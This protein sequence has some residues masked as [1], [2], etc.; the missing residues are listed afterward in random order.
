M[1]SFNLFNTVLLKPKQKMAVM[2]GMAAFLV[3]LILVTSFPPVLLAQEFSSSPSLGDEGESVEAVS[4]EAVI[5]TAE[6]NATSEPVVVSSPMLQ[7][8]GGSLGDEGEGNGAELQDASSVLAN[9][10][11]GQEDSRSPPVAQTVTGTVTFPSVTPLTGGDA[12]AEGLHG[13]STSASLG[14]EGEFISNLPVAGQ[15]AFPADEASSALADGLLIPTSRPSLGDEG[16]Q[17]STIAAPQTALSGG[18]SSSQQQTSTVFQCPGPQIPV[19][20]EDAPYTPWH[21]EV[22]SRGCTIVVWGEA[23]VPPASASIGDERPVT[24]SITASTP[25]DTAIAA[26]ASSGSLGNEGERT[27]TTVSAPATAATAASS[28]IPETAGGSLGDE[29]DAWTWTSS[30]ATTPAISEGIPATSGSIGDEGDGGGILGAP[31]SANGGGSGV[32]GGGNSS[33]NATPADEAAVECANPSAATFAELQNLIVRGRVLVTDFSVN[34]FAQ[35]GV[36]TVRNGTECTFSVTLATYEVFFSGDM[37]LFQTDPTSANPMPIGDGDFANLFVDLP[38]CM[39]QT[40]LL[41]GS[42]PPARLSAGQSFGQLIGTARTALEAGPFCTE[43]IPVGNQVAEL[44]VRSMREGVL[45][46]GVSVSGSQNGTSGVTAYTVTKTGENI[47]TVLS[48]PFL[49][50]NQNRFSGWS[51]DCTGEQCTIV[52]TPGTKKTVVANYVS[53]LPQL[54]G[55]CEAIPGTARTGQSIFWRVTASG[56]QGDY[57][58]AW[59]TGPDGSVSART[60]NPLTTFVYLTPGMKTM[61]A[62]IFSGPQVGTEYQSI[63]VTCQAEILPLIAPPPTG[64]S[65]LDTAPIAPPPTG[66]S[67]GDEGGNITAPP[68]GASLGDENV[69]IGAPPTGASL[70]DEGGNITT[71]PTGASIG[72]ENVPIGAPPTGASL[73]DEG[74]NITTPPTGASIG[75][76]NVPIGAPPTQASVGDEG[77]IPPPPAQPTGGGGGPVSPPPTGPV[78]GRTSGGGSFPLMFVIPT[79][80]QDCTGVTVQWFSNQPANGY[81]VYGPLSIASTTSATSTFFGYTNQQFS[82]STGLTTNHQVSITGLVPGVTYFFRPVANFLGH[83]PV[84]GPEISL[85]VQN[86]NCG[87]AAPVVKAECPYIWDSLGLGRDNNPEQVLR[88]QV[89]LKTVAGIDTPVTGIFDAQTEA[90]VRIFQ[91]RYPADILAPWGLTEPTGFVGVTTKRKINELLGCATPISVTK[92]APVLIG[93]SVKEEYNLEDFAEKEAYNV[94]PDILNGDALNGNG[95]NSTK[96]TTTSATSTALGGKSTSTL[97]EPIKNT[98]QN[99]NQRCSFTASRYTLADILLFPPRLIRCTGA[100]LIS[101]TINRDDDVPKE[102]TE[103]S[104]KDTI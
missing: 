96:A 66:G 22:D 42:N 100:I 75:D 35:E 5:S 10:S 95:R 98:V 16:T 69:P 4:Q 101:D 21:Y 90:A 85:T 72:D 73:G 12:E 68:T 64:A 33:Q 14:D 80:R 27:V 94:N 6:S 20:A 30:A 32:G 78:L 104:I 99:L 77:I 50:Q 79:V 36:V 91:A 89:F 41:F 37:R 26:P 39:S 46:T 74:G 58:F 87:G 15:A 48:V 55:S 38:P 63:V 83:A 49:D 81:V 86:L 57:R 18:G 3:C 43:G 71:P 92:A 29:A 23:P 47:Q 67:I 51:G 102:E 45:T 70:G 76:E 13:L 44:E 84:L 60:A 40:V 53:P 17:S 93:P 25:A 88:L 11:L 56:G 54:T 28:D 9:P 7:S 59:D 65:T 31:A 61:R 97:A 19:M 1:H 82:T 2:Q 103:E 34:G 24:T 62:H 52:V 8:N